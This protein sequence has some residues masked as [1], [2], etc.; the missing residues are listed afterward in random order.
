MVLD[1]TSLEGRRVCVA[2]SDGSRIDECQLVSLTRGTDGQVW[3]CVD[4]HDVFVGLADIRGAW[5]LRR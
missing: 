5:E 4:D 2:L 3:L 1:L